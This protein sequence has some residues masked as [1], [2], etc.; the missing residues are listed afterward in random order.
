MKSV[1]CILSASLFTGLLFSGCAEEKKPFQIVEISMSDFESMM[2]QG[3]TFPLLIEREGCTFCAAMNDY[4]ESTKNEHPGLTVYKIDATDYDL[5]RDD[6]EAKTLLSS[7]E[8]GKRLLEIF[9]FYLYTPV[10][11]AIEEGKPVSGGFGYDEAKH[12]VSLWNLSSTVDWT[13]ARPVYVWDY[14]EQAA[15]GKGELSDLSNASS[16]SSPEKKTDSKQAES[17]EKQKDSKAKDKSDKADHKDDSIKKAES[18][19]R[20]L[21]DSDFSADLSEL[22]KE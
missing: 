5:Y 13:L 12:T 22:E 2:E 1:N 6:P 21:A 4:I 7:T 9:P 17:S 11:Y 3:K 16:S 10:I 19:V 15:E 18:N 14:F 20:S 8:D